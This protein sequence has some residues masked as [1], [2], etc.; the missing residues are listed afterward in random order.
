MSG[1]GKG[2]KGLSI[3]GAKRHCKVLSDNIW[4]SP[5]RLAYS[6]AYLW[7]KE[8]HQEEDCDCHGCSLC[9]E[10]V[11]CKARWLNTNNSLLLICVHKLGCQKPTIVLFSSL[12]AEHLCD[13]FLLNPHIKSNMSEA[14][15]YDPES[16]VTYCVKYNT[17]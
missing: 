17:I 13:F 10:E 9:S 14:A 1:R 6:E 8:T 3:G 7:S 11:L 4:E 2:G 12:K 5:S 15:K 16:Y